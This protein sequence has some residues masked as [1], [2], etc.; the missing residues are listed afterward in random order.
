MKN[1]ISV[2]LITCLITTPVLGNDFCL[3]SK[4]DDRKILISNGKNDDVNSVDRFTIFSST[5]RDVSSLDGYSNSEKYRKKELLECFSTETHKSL[6]PTQYIEPLDPYWEGS[7][8]DVVFITS[9]C[10]V[11]DHFKSEPPNFYQHHK[12]TDYQIV[13]FYPN[14][15]EGSDESVNLS[16]RSVSGL[17]GN[18]NVGSTNELNDDQWMCNWDDQLVWVDDVCNQ[19]DWKTVYRRRNI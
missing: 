13:M 8:K 16:V 18:T 14:S 1:I 19:N 15:E 4:V 6:F 2:C 10:L 17:C 11:N 5:N 3:V 7:V 12:R 9:Y